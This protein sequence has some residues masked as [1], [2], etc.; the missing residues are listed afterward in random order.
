MCSCAGLVLPA[1]V[2]GAP[3]VCL[4]EVDTR[5]VPDVQASDGALLPN[6]PG[7]EGH[8]ACRVCCIQINTAGK[9]ATLARMDRARVCG[10]SASLRF[11][12]NSWSEF[13]D[14]DFS[15]VGSGIVAFTQHSV[16][17]RPILWAS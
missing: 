13:W 2:N 11:Q 16:K 17:L 14:S 7:L 15:R 6:E 9:S 8:A 5:C 12:H 4:H 10:E 3:P 1:V